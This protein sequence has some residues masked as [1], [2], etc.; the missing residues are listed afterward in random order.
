MADYYSGGG[1]S[2]IAGVSTNSPNVTPMVAD[3][4]SSST[5]AREYDPGIQQFIANLLGRAAGT[6]YNVPEYTKS[7]LE[8]ITMNPG[9]TGDLAGQQM[10]Q[11]MAPLL[12]EQAEGQKLQNQGMMDMFRKAGMGSLQSGAFAQAA[13]HQAADQGRA[14]ERI[15]SANY[16]PLLGE[17]NKTVFGGINAG[18]SM[19]GSEAAGQQSLN[20]ILGTLYQNPTR[21]TTQGTE[22]KLVEG[23]IATAR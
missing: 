10:S 14:Q 9:A 22:A 15:I 16:V 2:P 8:N 7:A 4:P 21:T 13:R 1:T 5:T 20:Q 19:P 11:I 23:K 3:L 17:A 12:R 6:N 18:L